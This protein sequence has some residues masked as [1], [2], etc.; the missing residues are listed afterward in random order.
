M[1]SYIGWFSVEKH[2]YTLK[3]DLKPIEETITEKDQRRI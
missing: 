2:E 1:N 3:V